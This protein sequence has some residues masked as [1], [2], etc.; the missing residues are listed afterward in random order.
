MNEAPINQ[1]VERA[2][3]MLGFF[4]AEEPELTLPQL[5]E[6]LGTARATTHRYAMALRRVGLLRYDAAGG[7]YSLGPR[8]VELAATAL[9]GLRII[10]IA[11]PHMERLAAN[12]NET[13]VLSIWDGESPIVVRVADNTDRLVHIV[14]RTGSRLERT[15]SA[16]GKVFLAFTGQGDELPPRELKRILATHIAVNTQTHDGI[17]AVATPVFQDRE[18]IATMAVVGTIANLP[19][20]DDSKLARRLHEAAELLSAELG[21]I[22]ERSIA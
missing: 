7:I 11:G 4:S 13:V 8:I 10:R 12:V 19:D 21:F 5:T 20:G 6:R 15:E 16:Q 22:A 9:S 2:V 14:V 1:S 17:R 3:R 18:V